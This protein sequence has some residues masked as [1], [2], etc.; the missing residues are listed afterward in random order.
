MLPLISLD[1][2]D[3]SAEVFERAADPQPDFPTDSSLLLGINQLLE[4]VS[5]PIIDVFHALFYIKK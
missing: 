5:P 2:D 4:T 1:D 3:A